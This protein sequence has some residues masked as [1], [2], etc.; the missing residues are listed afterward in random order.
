MNKRKVLI[1]IIGVFCLVV[2]LFSLFLIPAEFTSFYAFSEG[3]NFYYK[4]FG[5]GSLMFAFIILNVLAYFTL[6]VSSIPLGIGN[7]TLKK[8]GLNLSLA[9]SKTTLIIG[10]ATLIS[11]LSSFDLI[12]VLEPYQTLIILTFFLVFLIIVPYALIRFYK[13]PKTTQLFQDS[14]PDNDFEKQ[15]PI[16]LTII[17][18]NLFWILIFYLFI[19]LKGVF[20]LFGDFVFKREGT[21]LL[22]TAIFGLFVLTYLFYKNKYYVK[23]LMIIYYIILLFA[24]ML[25]FLKFSTNDLVS[26][27]N[28]PVYEIEKVV[29][30]FWIPAGINLGYFFGTMLVIQI[31]LIFRIKKIELENVEKILKT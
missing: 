5:F 24:F 25:T 26:L 17:L 20:P 15:P 10:I 1:K 8:W 9:F 12:K 11:F 29:P 13:N 30:A 22:S 31:Y 3:S 21:Y 28:L 23:F 7:F 19:F 2:G 6:A 16:N 27:L 18:L 14:I 4:G